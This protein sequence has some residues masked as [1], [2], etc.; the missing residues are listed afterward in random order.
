MTP[1]VFIVNAPRRRS[2]A[3]GEFEPIYNLTPA[4]AFGTLEFI[5]KEP[6]PLPSFDSF[7]TVKR[8]MNKMTADDFLMVGIGHPVILT[9]ATSVATMKLNGR[10]KTLSWF[11]SQNRYVEDLCVDASIP[12]RETL[13]AFAARIDALA[14]VDGETSLGV[15][16][17]EPE[18]WSEAYADGLLPEEAWANELAEIRGAA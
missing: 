5:F 14:A 12:S 11:K 13:E 9:W 17:C 16:Y 6:N 2:H 8:V 10:I 4:M 1:R 18:E 3:T 7:E 15:P